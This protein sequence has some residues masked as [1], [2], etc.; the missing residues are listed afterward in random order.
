MAVF[1]C[2]QFTTDNPKRIFKGSKSIKRIIAIPAMCLLSG[3]SFECGLHRDNS[4]IFCFAHT[5]ESRINKRI[6]S[7]FVFYLTEAF[8]KTAKNMVFGQ[9]RGVNT[10]KK[11]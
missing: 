5:Y 2:L 10:R 1:L 11:A 3:A 4:K 9:K 7:N 8:Q 6:E